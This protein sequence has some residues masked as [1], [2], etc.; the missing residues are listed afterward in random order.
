MNKLSANLLQII[1]DFG[2]TYDQLQFNSCNKKTRESCKITY[3]D[4]LDKCRHN[5]KK[6]KHVKHLCMSA[7][8]L[9]LCGYD[10]S[11]LTCECKELHNE[12]RSSCRSI[13][14]LNMTKIPRTMICCDMSNYNIIP[15]EIII[16]NGLAYGSLINMKPTKLVINGNASY[17]IKTN[18]IDNPNLRW[19]EIYRG[20]IINSDDV[21]KLTMLEHF[22]PPP[23]IGNEDIQPLKLK[24]LELMPSSK[25]TDNGIKNMIT[26][27]RL[28]IYSYDRI[29]NVGI[30]DLVNLEELYIAYNSNCKITGNGLK[31]LNLRKLTICGGNRVSS[32]DITHMSKL[33]I[34]IISAVKEGLVNIDDIKHLTIRELILNEKDISKSLPCNQS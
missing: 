6:Y 18:I 15:Y 24:S 21:K 33:R 9:Y 13:K 4:D 7:D 17:I 5:I 14:I 32:A 19:L 30:C 31:K 27:Q 28:I 25:I 26:L 2:Q 23:D 22:T 3:I 29:T 12:Y 11:H 10:I 8:D 1:Q 16:D 34:L 20:G